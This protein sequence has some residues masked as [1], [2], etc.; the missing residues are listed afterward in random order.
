MRARW[1]HVPVLALGLRAAASA[2]VVVSPAAPWGD[3]L[4]VV[5]LLPDTGAQNCVQW[6][7]PLVEGQEILLRGTPL[8]LISYCGYQSLA[9]P[10]N[11]PAGRYHVD[12]RLQD[13]TAF[14]EVYFTKF[15]QP[16]VF[17]E[18]EVTIRPPRPSNAQPVD[19]IVSA[20]ESAPCFHVVGVRATTIT[21]QGV[22]IDLQGSQLPIECPPSTP[23][24]HGFVVHAAALSS[25]LKTLSVTVD[26]APTLERRF[27]VLDATTPVQLAERF[28]TSVSW[29]DPAGVEHV[30][31]PSRLSSSSATF[32]FGDAMNVEL[33]VKALDGRPLNRKF[34]IFAASLTDQPW[35]LHVIDRGSKGC[36]S[37]H[38]AEKLYTGA[39]HKNA[40][41]L[42]TRAF[43]P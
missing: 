16:Y 25:G 5:Y 33:T 26:G 3:E 42:D 23:E 6:N 18:G 24:T 22:T 37:G 20:V 17:S 1:L 43:D 4:I 32:S 2:S 9:L 34:W 38:C 7:L 19:F 14:G 39:A 41:V 12:A 13:G 27:T 31:E 28:E 30:A 21:D 15:D 40:N 11:L 36:A 8:P 10:T 29:T 35:T